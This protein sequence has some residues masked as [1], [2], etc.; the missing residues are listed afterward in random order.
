MLES[1]GHQRELD[2]FMATTLVKDGEPIIRAATRLPPEKAG[3][4]FQQVYE[5]LA[6]LH[7]AGAA[8]VDISTGNVLLDAAGKV[9]FVDL[10]NVQLNADYDVLKED[11]LMLD[12][13]VIEMCRVMGLKDKGMLQVLAAGH[14]EYER[15]IKGNH[16]M[17]AN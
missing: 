5:S 9:W 13:V 3:R 12:E 1:S 2:P 11:L 17:H 6:Q 14:R 4:V 16:H 10:E 8:H 7:S 15:A